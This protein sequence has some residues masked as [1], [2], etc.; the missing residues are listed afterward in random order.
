MPHLFEEII[1]YLEAPDLFRLAVALEDVRELLEENRLYQSINYEVPLLRRGYL[2]RQGYWVPNERS[3]GSLV[4][5]ES[6]EKFSKLLQLL[7]SENTGDPWTDANLRVCL[8]L[9]KSRD[10]A[11]KVSSFLDANNMINFVCHGPLSPSSTFR[12]RQH[13]GI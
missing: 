4:A 11:V 8:V 6:T 3:H 13:E 10:E 2:H 5:V 12:I 1:S 9:A 7:R